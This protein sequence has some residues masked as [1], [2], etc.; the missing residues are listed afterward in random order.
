[1]IDATGTHP[2]GAQH[3]GCGR[4]SAAAIESA[5]VPAVVPQSQRVVGVWA[6]LSAVAVVPWL[7]H[8]GD[9]GTAGPAAVQ[10]SGGRM[11]PSRTAWALALF[12]GA[13]SMQAYVTFGWFALFFQEEAGFTEARSELM[14]AFLAGLSIPCRSPSRT[15]PPA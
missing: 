13:Q 7:P 2:R 15:S 14:V 5:G 12:F 10:R 6:A 3:M 4:A 11:P 9:R 8:L 1:V